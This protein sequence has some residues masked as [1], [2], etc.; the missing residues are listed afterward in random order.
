MKSIIRNVADAPV[1]K[2]QC[3]DCPWRPDAGREDMIA[4]LEVHGEK[5][6]LCHNTVA[7]AED[8]TG[9]MIDVVVSPRNRTCKGYADYAKGVA[10]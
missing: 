7:F 5:T 6:W 9:R 2:K 3:A 1:I 10:E 4:L 8:H